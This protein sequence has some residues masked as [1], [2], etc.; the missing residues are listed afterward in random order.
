MHFS[1]NPGGRLKDTG[2]IEAGTGLWHAPNR[3]ASN[4]SGFAG[5]PGG[6][7]AF[8][9][10]WIGYYGM[11]WSSTHAGVR[12]LDYTDGNMDAGFDVKWIGHSV[13]C[14]KD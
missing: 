8:Y 11:W 13:R 7:R 5:L 12:D 2:T 6:W 4:R 10:D 3:D 14:I 9:F 1:R